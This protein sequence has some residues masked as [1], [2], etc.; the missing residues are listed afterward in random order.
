M[1]EIFTPT[2]VIAAALSALMLWVVVAD[3]T[4]YIIPNT[5]NALVI[6]LY[7]PAV[8]LLPVDPLPALGTA[9]LMLLLGLGIFSLGVMGGGDVKLLVAIS[10]WTGWSIATPQFLFATAMFGGVVAVLLLFLRWVAGLKPR[11]EEGKSLPRILSKKQPIPY[12]IAIAA[13]FS[14]MVWRGMIP[15]LPAVL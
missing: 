2:L 10:L 15:G 13:A 1:V 3:A 9:A 12:G 7:I 11:P 4:R 5:L 8:F 14:W 6:L